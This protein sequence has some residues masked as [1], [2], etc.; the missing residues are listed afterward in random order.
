M[1]TRALFLSAIVSVCLVPSVAH[2]SDVPDPSHPSVLEVSHPTVPPHEISEDCYDVNQ[3][4]AACTSEWLDVAFFGVLS[5][6]ALS[7]AVTSLA[8]CG[9][10]MVGCVAVPLTFAASQ[11]AMDEFM[12]SVGALQECLDAWQGAGAS[13]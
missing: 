5:S 4:Q 7:E 13:F 3:Q 12:D 1:S 11:V 8:A 6:A 2:A 9:A 10:T